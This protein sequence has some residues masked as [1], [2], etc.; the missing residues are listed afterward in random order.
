MAKIGLVTAVV[1]LALIS[2]SGSTETQ[3]GSDGKPDTGR[4]GLVVVHEQRPAITDEELIALLEK[5][6]AGHISSLDFDVYANRAFS[7][8]PIQTWI[9]EKHQEAISYMYRGIVVS[10]SGSNSETIGTFATVGLADDVLIL[11]ARYVDSVFFLSDWLILDK[12][13]N[14][15]TIQDLATVS[16]PSSLIGQRVDYSFGLEHFDFENDPLVY[17]QWFHPD[18]IIQI[19]P[20]AGTLELIEEVPED[21]FIMIEGV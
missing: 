19:D 14:F 9:A 8:S 20:D 1:M 6:E 5:I 10:R 17:D 4:N 15:V 18:A 3:E 7:S 2:C 16:D 12:R 11:Y 13:E 21:Q